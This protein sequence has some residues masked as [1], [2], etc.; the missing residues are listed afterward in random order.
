[1]NNEPAVTDCAVWLALEVISPKWSV[2]IIL[3]LMTAGEDSLSYSNLQKLIP[4]INPRMLAMR[5]ESL[6][7]AGLIDRVLENRL[8][9]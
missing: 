1:M 7:E 6:Y 5:L 4:T 3:E 8:Y 9:K 2:H